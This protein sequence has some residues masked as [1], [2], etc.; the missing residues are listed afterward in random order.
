MEQ[1]NPN[2]LVVKTVRLNHFPGDKMIAVFVLKRGEKPLLGNQV[3]NVR[4]NKSW[5]ESDTFALF[6]D[7]MDEMKKET[8]GIYLERKNHEESKND[9]SRDS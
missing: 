1:N 7:K 2:D 8:L 4:R 9:S 5:Y 3:H 6:C